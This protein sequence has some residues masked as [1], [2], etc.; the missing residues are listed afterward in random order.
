MTD[1]EPRSI[2]LLAEVEQVGGMFIG[3]DGRP[4]G[5]SLPPGL[6]FERYAAL[7]HMFWD[8]HNLSRWCI[9]DIL[10][11]A[12]PE[13]RND[14]YAQ[15]ISLTQLSQNTLENYASTSR[16]VPPQRRRE[17]VGHSIH[18]EVKSLP[19][20]SQKR[21]LAKAEREQLTKEA[22]RG[23]VREE[24][25]HPPEPIAKEVCESCGRPI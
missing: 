18:V 25:G 17:N 22:V 13:Y 14:I 4:V 16:L 2:Q 11:A 20:A 23:L 3:P 7:L 12:E 15:A 5:V 9:G 24:K 6:P 8:V 1:L 19:A 10:A 21:L